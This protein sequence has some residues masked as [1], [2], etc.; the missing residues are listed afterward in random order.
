MDPARRNQEGQ[1]DGAAGRIGDRPGWRVVRQRRF[2]WSCVSRD[3]EPAV[4]HVGAGVSPARP[5]KARLV[6][7]RTNNGKSRRASLAHPDETSGPTWWQCLRGSA[8]LLVLLVNK[9]VSHACD[10]VA[11]HTRQGLLPRFL[12]IA[13]RQAFWFRHPEVEELANHALRVILFR[14]QC[15]AE[16]EVLV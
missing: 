14:L 11:N 15:G 6:F 7:D 13:L 8:I 10:V 9:I 16:V 5:G 4:K 12:L 3:L 2:R 1:V